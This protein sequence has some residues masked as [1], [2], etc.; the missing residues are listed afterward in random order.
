MA[1]FTYAVAGCLAAFILTDADRLAISSSAPAAT[2]RARHGALDRAEPMQRFVALPLR[3]ERNMGQA[4]ASVD[5][6]VHGGSY[7]L[8]LANAEPVLTF[9]G[10]YRSKESA[11][12]Q[13]RMSFLDRNAHSAPIY[14]GELPGRSNYLVGKSTGWLRDIRSYSSIEYKQV[15][16]GIDV[17]F[18]GH[19][20]QLEY[21]FVIEPGADPRRIQFVFDGA[22]GVRLQENG[23]LE[24]RVGTEL[25]AF[26][27]PDVYQE[28]VD[29]RRSTIA[30]AYQLEGRNVRFSLGSYDQS[31]AL[32]IDPVLVYSIPADPTPSITDDD[33]AAGVAVDVGG[34]AY[35]FNTLN[36]RFGIGSLVGTM[37]V[38]KLDPTGGRVYSTNLGSGQAGAIAVSPSGEVFVAGKG[39]FPDAPGF[40]GWGFDFSIVKLNAAGNAV[41][42]K[43]TIGND[44][45]AFEALHLA[46]GPSGQVALTGAVGPRNFT[47]ENAVQP[48]HGGGGYDAFALLL[49]ATG[50]QLVFSTYLGGSAVDVGHGV[51]ISDDGSIRVVGRTLSANFPTASALQP[52]LAGPADG[53]VT[54]FSP[55]GA[56][57]Q[58]TFL[59]GSG[60]DTVMGVGLGPLGVMHVAG[61]TD[62]LDF[63]LQDAIDTSRHTAFVTRLAPD[64]RSL[65]YSTYFG[66]T[67]EDSVSAV[68]ADA[69]NNTYI[70]GSTTSG[71]FP[72]RLPIHVY[73]GGSDGFVAKFGPRGDLLHSTYLGGAGGGQIDGLAVDLE[74]NVYVVGQTWA[75]MHALA[76]IAKL[77]TTLAVTGIS[78]TLIPSGKTGRVTL[79][80]RNFAIGARVFVGGRWVTDVNVNSPT[81]LSVTLPALTDGNYDIVV[82]NPPAYDE[83]AL[84]YNAVDYLLCSFTLPSTLGFTGNGGV[85][86]IPVPSMPIGCAWSAASAD[87]WIAVDPPFAGASTT[88]LRITV[89]ANAGRTVRRGTISV[90]GQIIEITQGPSGLLDIDFDRKLDLIWHHQTDGRLAVW[91]MNGTVE[92][93]GVSL[94]PPSVPDTSWKVVGSADLDQDGQ[95]DLV[96]QNVADGR[97]AAW[98]MNGLTCREGLL[99]SPDQVADTGW[100]IRAVGDFSG[101]GKADLIWQHE[102]Q[103]LVA[104]WI[105][106]GLQLI[107]G[108]LLNMPASGLT[109]QVVGGGDFNDDGY[110]DLVWQ[111]RVSGDISIWLM[112]ATNVADMVPVPPG[113]GP[114]TNWAIR[115][116]GDVDGDGRPDLIW[117]HRLNGGL[118]CWLMDGTTQRTAISLTPGEVADTN[119]HMVGPR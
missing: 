74:S 54:T 94:W 3:F 18:Y 29:G 20:G 52:A 72:L 10:R 97:V 19:D 69:R 24:V 70:A 5:A 27:A 11:S 92:T 114:D 21:D 93:A 46:V 22:D 113:S 47:L 55:A 66:G 25:I 79:T 68:A 60:T 119:W 82:V 42:Y 76:R 104:I 37:V 88:A 14:N 106:N 98:L 71:D 38:T 111:N 95:M 35:S 15:Y 80:G 103:G 100:Q 51:A 50:D 85:R 39:T 78:P 61:K 4:A 89:A 23:A 59:G 6:L 87:S 118:A 75:V 56:L 63:P 110:R 108:R 57:L 90:A 16:P 64:G 44:I 62:S 105:M 12:R 49:N 8:L 48:I 30:A 96:W 81:S 58:S 28:R 2:V 77:A 102:T 7:S 43:A 1:G 65:L 31:R 9:R 91:F 112:D 41:I 13:V 73:A 53:F 109:W 17:I 33:Y 84:L 26:A 83:L 67:G 45:S 116:V 115:A 117:Q 99:L 101:D 86:S 36:A 34:N 32:V 107:D 40:R